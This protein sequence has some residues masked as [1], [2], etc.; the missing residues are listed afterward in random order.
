MDSKK[1]KQ[2]PQNASQSQ[3]AKLG[4]RS[5]SVAPDRVEEANPEFSQNYK[6][7]SK[8]NYLSIFAHRKQSTQLQKPVSKSEISVGTLQIQQSNLHDPYRVLK[9][10]LK[11]NPVEKPEPSIHH[12]Y[13]S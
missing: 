10:K 4:T 2:L 6:H 8:R 1:L 9:D 13:Y 12:Y 7:F 11:P 5:K 3:M